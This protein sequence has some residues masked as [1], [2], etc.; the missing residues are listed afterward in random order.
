LV[1]TSLQVAFGVHNGTLVSSI[2]RVADVDQ[3]IVRRKYP[4]RTW[5][6]TGNPT[7]QVRNC[8]SMAEEEGRRQDDFNDCD[9]PVT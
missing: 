7:A 3:G 9:I 2:S 4:N 8:G 5:P 1:D 6:G